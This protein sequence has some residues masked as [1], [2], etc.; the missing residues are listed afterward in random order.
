MEGYDNLAEIL[1]EGAH[2]RVAEPRPL[3][4]FVAM[5]M[6]HCQFAL[7]NWVP[8]DVKEEDRRW[9][10][11]RNAAVVGGKLYHV[12]MGEMPEIGAVVAV[13]DSLDEARSLVKERAERVGGYNLEIHTEALDSAE[14][15]IER[16]REFGV[17]FGD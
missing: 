1:W 12:P 5:A 10:K 4:K 9:V 16:G 13:A 7:T 15:E 6:I 14:E 2:G 3:G 17:E 11:L 8:I